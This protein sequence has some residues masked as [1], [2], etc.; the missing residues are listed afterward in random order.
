MERRMVGVSRLLH[1]A[2]EDL[3]SGSDIKDVVEE[4]YKRK[5]RRVGHLT[6]R[7]TTDGL[8]ESLNATREVLN[9]HAAD[10]QQDGKIRRDVYMAF[11]GCGDLRS[12]QM[13]NFAS[14]IDGENDEIDE[15]TPVQ[16][17]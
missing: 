15:F 11:I 3:R 10:H 8:S 5:E 4:M 2:N 9:D 16:G 12:R 1:T 14:C 7:K 17:I 6:S 13:E